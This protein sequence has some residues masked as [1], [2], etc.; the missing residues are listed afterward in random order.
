MGK[1]TAFLFSGQGTQYVGMGKELYD[2]YS[3]FEQVYNFAQQILDKDIKKLSFNGNISELKKTINTQP[4][5]FTLE[6]AIYS[7]LDKYSVFPDVVAGYSLG[8]YA[9]LYACGIIDLTTGF[10]L[11]NQR[12]K[13]MDK[14]SDDNEYSMYAIIGDNISEIDKI[15]SEFE[16]VWVAN[17]NT[18]IQVT[19][20][21]KNENVNQLINR[22]S[23]LGYSVQKIIVSGA[24]HSKFMKPAADCF[25]KSFDLVLFKD[26]KIPIL[27][28]LTGDYYN[29]DISNIKVILQKQ[30]YSPV[31]WN[32][33]INRMLIDGVD[34]FIEIGPGKTLSNFVK[35]ISGNRPINVFNVDNMDTLSAVIDFF[36]D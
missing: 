26:N 28:N 33:I 20:T 6:T 19:V 25:G 5:I 21:G 23:S 3:E 15:C 29:K 2:R 36:Y 7:V 27:L 30:M 14:F 31:K 16:N 1:K 22:V 8:E 34:T 10:Y 12:A 32:Q 11:V 35:K 17:Y 18:Q 13:A 24:F 9:A 4:A